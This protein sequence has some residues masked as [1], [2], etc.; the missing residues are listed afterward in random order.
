MKKLHWVGAAATILISASALMGCSGDDPPPANSGGSGN[1]AGSGSMAGAGGSTGGM[2]AGVQ[3]KPSASFTFLTGADAVANPTAAPAAWMGSG[4]NSCHGAN[5]EGV[6]PI[7]PEV[8]HTPAVY[9]QWIVR[10]GRGTG[11]DGAPSAMVAF[12]TTSTMQ[13]QLAIDD[14]GLTAV[15]GWLNGAPKPTTGAG[16]YK[17]FCGNCHGPMTGTGGNIPISV[18][19]KKRSEIMMKIRMGEGTDAAMRNLYMPPYSATELTD[20]EVGLIS[21]F[22]MATN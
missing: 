15:I 1:M 6:N 21:D 14:A 2:S 3:L 4:C 8:R 19:G 10:H 22:L 12:P 13:G 18:V 11:T 17:D 16:L 7:G 5:G 9:A 20:A